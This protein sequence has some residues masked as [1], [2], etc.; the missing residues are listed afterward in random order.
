MGA[1]V[2]C[3]PILGKMSK[4]PSFYVN[5]RSWAYDCT[6]GKLPYFLLSQIVLGPTRDAKCGGE[7]ILVV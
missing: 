7:G 1:R 6:D 4:L 5:E 2:S 3:V